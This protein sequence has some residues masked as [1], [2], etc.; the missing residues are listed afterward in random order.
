MK[1]GGRTDDDNDA[2][3]ASAASYPVVGPSL[4]VKDS[5]QATRVQRTNKQTQT[6]KG[7]QAAVAAANEQ[8]M[9]SR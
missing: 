2:G 3:P 9:R 1:S 6:V 5:L 4:R 7:V 8:V